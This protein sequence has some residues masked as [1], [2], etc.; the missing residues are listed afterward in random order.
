MR[1]SIRHFLAVAAALLLVSA[2]VALP[3]AAGAKVPN[4]AARLAK[5][6]AAA[7]GAGLGAA[8][9]AIRNTPAVADL[10]QSLGVT[11][12][13]TQRGLLTFVSRQGGYSPHQL[14]REL[15]RNPA[16]AALR[17]RG[18]QLAAHPGLLRGEW[19][20][21]T[22]GLVRR[23]QLVG[24]ETSIG[25]AE[26][27][28]RRPLAVLGGK[29][30][31]SAAATLLS[32]GAGLRFVSALPPIAL[33]VLFPPASRGSAAA[34]VATASS[35]SICASGSIY[36]SLDTM[37]GFIANSVLKQELED[38][39]SDAGEKLTLQGV[40]KI[41]KFGAKALSYRVAK[42]F[43]ETVNL[44]LALK[45]GMDMG[46]DL[47]DAAWN[48]VVKC[49]A[50]E[51]E[52]VP[53][54]MTRAAGEPQGYS[55]LAK[56]SKGQSWGGIRADSLTLSNGTCYVGPEE[57][58]GESVGTGV[59]TAAFG[60]LRATTLL[61]VTPGPIAKLTIEP[62]GAKIELGEASPIYHVEASDRYGDP[63]AAGFGDGAG[64][65]RLSIS[66]DGTCDQA[67]AT[68]TPEKSGFH[69][70]TVAVG[71]NASVRATA[72]LEAWQELE[73]TTSV[74]SPDIPK[75]Y[76]SQ[77]IEAVGGIGS[78]TWSVA[79]GSL[80]AGVALSPATGTLSGRPTVNSPAEL[81]TVMHPYQFEVEVEDE[82]GNS[83]SA[84]LTLEVEPPPCSGSPCA[85]ANG[86]GQ[87]TLAYNSCGCAYYPGGPYDYETAAYINGSFVA[88]ERSWDATGIAPG[89]RNWAVNTTAGSSFLL[90][91][92]SVYYALYRYNPQTSEYTSLG[93]SNTVVVK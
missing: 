31:T 9:E 67:K 82:A 23:G 56:D 26:A 89:E 5:V 33:G 78:H 91:G 65:L 6:V 19:K 49:G 2:I 69:Q 21:L 75:V 50:H 83:A 54:N 80:P 71:G 62:G 25:R 77:M 30:F 74:L 8:L 64:E 59:V 70:I 35:A 47:V 38:I 1:S 90:A 48:A 66:P 32:S 12:M 10:P 55:L 92:Q 37:L 14:V 93:T 11:L 29:S 24:E 45:D 61:T 42:R 76:N 18:E 20:R 58:V 39:L 52:I 16:I 28:V 88:F 86:F 46:K 57:C 72:T 63:V 27:I 41:A 53:S 7:E 81:L 13:P 60:T 84:E 36:P 34:S 44:A 17:K 51:I 73:I 79:S 3:G 87:V 68:C 40:Y 22:S 15:G 85:V 4:T 43:I